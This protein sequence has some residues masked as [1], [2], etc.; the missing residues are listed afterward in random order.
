MN[1]SIAGGI[2]NKRDG[3]LPSTALIFSL[4]LRRRAF[5]VV[6]LQSD[7]SICRGLFC[8]LF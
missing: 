3:D 1:L 6:G 4:Q 5:L 7:V 8:F 2:V